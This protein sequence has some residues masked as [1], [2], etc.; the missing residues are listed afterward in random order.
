MRRTRLVCLPVLC[1]LLLLPNE[2]T[3]FAAKKSRPASQAAPASPATVASEVDRLIAA[4]L[5][6]GHITPADRCN[7]EDF[8]R[9]ASL[10]VIG[11]LPSPEKISLFVLNPDPHK[12]AKL[13]DQLLASDDYGRNWG[14]Y[15]RDVV[16]TMPRT[17]SPG[18]ASRR[19]KAGSPHSSMKITPGIRSLQQC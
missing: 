14:R 10:D 3:A 1:G 12:R 9:R 18:S 19:L 17:I 4:G 16:F 11:K 7:D 5:S 15:W 8:L 6:Q 13:I 2:N